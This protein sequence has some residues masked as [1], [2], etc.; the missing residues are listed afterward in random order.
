[1]GV[2][3]SLDPKRKYF[4]LPKQIIYVL[5]RLHIV[6]LHRHQPLLAPLAHT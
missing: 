5:Q 4:A 3:E 6:D 2:D 1:L